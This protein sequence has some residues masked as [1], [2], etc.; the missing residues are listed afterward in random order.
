MH[1]LLAVMAAL[2]MGSL[3]LAAAPAGA[4]PPQAVDFTIEETISPLTTGT[5]V[6]GSI[7]GCDDP[8]VFTENV[9]VGGGG[10]VQTF[11]GDKRFECANGDSFTLS[12]AARAVGCAATDAG[13]WRVVSATGGLTGLR[14]SGSLV[15][16]YVGGDACG[17]T[18][19]LDNYTGR[20]FLP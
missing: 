19:I 6:T 14:G 11:A 5:L 2:M 13:S 3:L 8:T 1:R 16:T 9:R 17:S 4:A 18:G 10:S 15:G 12:F 7:P 20:F